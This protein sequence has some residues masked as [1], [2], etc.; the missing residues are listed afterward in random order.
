MKSLLASLAGSFAL[1]LS[2]SVLA[3]QPEAQTGGPWAGFCAPMFPVFVDLQSCPE[4]DV[5][6]DFSVG[7]GY[8]DCEGCYVVVQGGVLCDDPHPSIPVQTWLLASGCQST[9][10][11]PIPCPARPGF[12]AGFVE[13]E[14]SKCF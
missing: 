7:S 13:L 4:C 11:F 3:P 9:S 2:M 12:A 8:A 10:F 5:F 14:C 1:C 6:F